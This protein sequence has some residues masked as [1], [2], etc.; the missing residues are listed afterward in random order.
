MKM[1]SLSLKTR[2]STR[3]MAIEKVDEEMEKE[4]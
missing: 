4:V 3:K 2:R 1:L